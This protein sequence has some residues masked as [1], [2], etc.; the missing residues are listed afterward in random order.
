MEGEIVFDQVSKKFGQTLAL[1][2][3]SFR[4]EPGE[5]VFLTGPSGSG[6]TTMA[7]LIT[8][9]ILPTS[10]KIKVSNFELLSLKKKQL[11][12]LRRS[13][14]VV[15]QDFKLLN[16]L[17]VWE[18]VILPLEISGWSKEKINREAEKVLK[19]TGILS[20][21]DLFPSQLAG[22]ELQRTCIARAAVG[23]PAIIIAD[24]PTGNLDIATAWQIINLLTKINELGRTI[25][26]MTH[27]FEIVNSC[28][29]R[30]LELEKGKLIRDDMKGY[31][32]K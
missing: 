28:N 21:R 29:K 26:V 12:L 31:R 10:G 6:K 15:F 19:I 24:E 18:N 23:K 16:D 20:K 1:V 11:P 8:K 2:E 5:F 25:L 7:R 30:V 17:T 32:I 13:L 22:G 14:G 4:I 3:V 27:N 9:E